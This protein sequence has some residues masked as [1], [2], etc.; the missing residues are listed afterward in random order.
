MLLHTGL[1]LARELV[2]RLM[3]CIGGLAL[4]L[5][6][7]AG[8]TQFPILLKCRSDRGT[9][10]LEVGIRSQTSLGTDAASA[11]HGRAHWVSQMCAA[12]KVECTPNVAATIITPNE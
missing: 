3:K 5:T 12:E 8:L 7:A 6:H 11:M 2:P 9:G 10:P 4:M 1:P